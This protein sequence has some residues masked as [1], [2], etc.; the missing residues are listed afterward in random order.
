MFTRQDIANRKNEIERLA[1][2]YGI[3]SVSLFG[4]VARGTADA[5]S[6]VDLLVNIQEGTSLLSLGGF[7]VEMER[8]L[9]RKVDVVTP[10]G[11]KERIRERALKEAV[12]L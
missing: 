5:S 1:H 11:L 2:K 8:L 12:A 10:A 3:Q 9:G 6:D 4:S 7:Q